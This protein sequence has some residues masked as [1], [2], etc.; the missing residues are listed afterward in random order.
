[1]NLK[2][3]KKGRSAEGKFGYLQSECV[4]LM[5]SVG[6]LAIF[7]INSH[8]ISTAKGGANQEFLTTTAA[9]VQTFPAV[10]T[11]PYNVKLKFNLY[12]YPNSK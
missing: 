12:R 7:S 6:K 3:S 9:G 1:M 2:N 8:R 4:R 10:T 5:F 11:I